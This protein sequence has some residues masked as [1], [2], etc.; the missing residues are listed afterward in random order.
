MMDLSYWF[1]WI[2]RVPLKEKLKF[3]LCFFGK[4]D[5]IYCTAGLNGYEA[6]CWRCL[7]VVDKGVEFCPQELYYYDDTKHECYL[8]TC[9]GC[10]HNVEETE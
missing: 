10:K 1:Y 4:H 5:I 6:T 7:K 9:D 8:D 3:L 2:K